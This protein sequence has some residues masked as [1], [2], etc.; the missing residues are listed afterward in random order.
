MD[1]QL[2]LVG[3][4]Q[5]AERVLVAGRARAVKSVVTVWSFHLLGFLPAG[6]QY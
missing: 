4:H 6:R 5:F 2:V 1:L 3:I